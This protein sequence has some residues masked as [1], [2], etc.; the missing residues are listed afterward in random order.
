MTDRDELTAKMKRWLAEQPGPASFADLLD[1][2]DDELIAFAIRNFQ[3][4]AREAAAKRIER[5]EALV[6][7][8]SQAQAKNAV[9][10]IF[11]GLAR[12]WTLDLHEQLA[13]LRFE[14]PGELA[15]LRQK[16]ATDVPPEAAERIAV[17]LGIFGA[18]NVLL[19]IPEHADAWI[20]APNNAP[21][22]GG[23]SALDLMLE[24]GPEGICTVRDHLHGQ[25]AGP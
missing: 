15:K 23:R 7:S 17:L 24:R 1:S 20:R 18:I 6:T 22:F 14:T 13:L 5:D 11:D 16:A 3:A 12:A 10:R 21:V 2:G 19:P 8:A 4:Q 9:L 25:L